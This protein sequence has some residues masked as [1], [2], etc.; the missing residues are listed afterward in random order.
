VVKCTFLHFKYL[1]KSVFR[2]P[3][4]NHELGFPVFNSLP[5]SVLVSLLAFNFARLVLTFV[6]S[7]AFLLKVDQQC[8]LHLYGLIILSF[9]RK[10]LRETRKF[11]PRIPHSEFNI[12]ILNTLIAQILKEKDKE[13]GKSK[14]SWKHC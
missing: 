6:Y 2:V 1:G 13:E 11:S 5:S 12:L 8:F 7:V 10:T 4:I 14:K 9:L 3:N